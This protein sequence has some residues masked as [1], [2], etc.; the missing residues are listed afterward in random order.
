MPKISRRRVLASAAS[1]AAIGALWRPAEAFEPKG[2]G[3]KGIRLGAQTNAWPIDPSNFNTLVDT[4]SQIRQVGY[5]GFETGFLNLRTQFKTPEK[6]RDRIAATSLTFFGVHIFLQ[7]YDYLTAIAPRDLYEP[8]ARV[9]AAIGAERLILSGAPAVTPEEVQR[10]ASAL[11]AAGEFSRNL[12]LTLA[13]H[14]HWPEFKWN[15]KEIE[16]LY[17]QTDPSL[18]AFVLDA[19]HAYRT[20]VDIP[21]F[22]TEHH[23]RL[24]GI[25][26]RDYREGNQVP[27]GQGTFPLSA[28]A[29]VLQD[30]SWSGWVLNEEER[31]DGSKLG[32]AAIEPAYQAARGAFPL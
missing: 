8:V 3:T 21:A 15:G 2:T 29:R 16:A 27:L 32:L 18:V 20:G 1:L 24:T 9:G 5:A 12:G 13:Y 22:V 31:E 26:L 28:L 10:K 4:L 6:A 14:N 17:A 23:Q 11:N 30:V 7:E 25:H 19:G